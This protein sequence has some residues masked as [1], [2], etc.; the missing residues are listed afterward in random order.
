MVDIIENAIQNH[1]NKSILESQT[2]REFE[3]DLEN[4]QLVIYGIGAGAELFIKHYADV[5]HIDCAIDNIKNGLMLRE[6]DFRLKD[7]SDL[8]IIIEKPEEIRK[9]SPEKTIILITALKEH[10]DIYNS[11]VRIGYYGVYSLLCME[12]NKRMESS[13]ALGYANPR[14]DYISYKLHSPT[15]RNS[16]FVETMGGYSGHARYIAESMLRKN[17]SLQFTWFNDGN[18]GYS[19]VNIKE[20]KRNTRSYYD[21]LYNAGLWLFEDPVYNDISK[22]SDQLLIQLKHWSSITLKAFGIKL[23]EP[24]EQ[25]YNL[26]TG[27]HRRLFEHNAKLTDYTITGSEFDEKTIREG[28]LYDGPF[29]RTGSPRSDILFDSERFRKSVREKYGISFDTKICLYVP[30]FRFDRSRKCKYQDMGIDYQGLKD[31]LEKISGE[32]WRIMLRLHPRTD[33]D[34]L[35]TFPGF[36]VNATDYMDGEE[37]VAAS[38]IV[39]ADYSS[40]MFEP[41]FVRKPVFLYAPDIEEYLENERGFLIPYEELPFPKAYSN[42]ELI[43]NITCFDE[44]KYVEDVDAFMDKYGVHEDGHA[45]ERAADFILGLLEDSD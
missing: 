30:T 11:L 41:A 1:W 22:K 24:L 28:Y 37:L 26:V 6:F 7:S 23:E 32:R 29:F 17:S 38:D 27:S 31:R 13:N 42:A 8:N 43:E 4:K 45:S 18:T 15:D 39:I 40:I 16:V 25:K 33:R 21:A 5:F 36:V 2:W 10:V 35:P 19:G 14:E 12:A 9:Y 20:V 44:K 3:K 34:T